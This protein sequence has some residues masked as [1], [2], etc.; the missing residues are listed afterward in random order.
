VRQILKLKYSQSREIW[1]RKKKG[2]G[3]RAQIVLN[4]QIKAKNLKQ[5]KE[6]ISNCTFGV[7]E[8]EKETK[9]K[10]ARRLYDRADFKECIEALK[11]MEAEKRTVELI[12]RSYFQLSEIEKGK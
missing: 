7:M 6:K 8:I 2:G 1:S 10:E 12:G 3:L 9:L 11:G 4:R 5:E